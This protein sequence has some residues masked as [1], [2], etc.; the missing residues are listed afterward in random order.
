[1][2]LATANITA[3]TVAAARRI[4]VAC[5]EFEDA[6]RAGCPGRWDECL[7][8][9][10]A[11]ERPALLRQLLLL[12]WEYR[13]ERGD[14]LDLTEYLAR[15]PEQSTLV[16]ETSEEYTIEA[17]A[18]SFS[19]PELSEASRR[20][21][22]SIGYQMLHPLGRGGM[23]TVY[24]ACQ[25]GAD[26]LVAIKLLGTAADHHPAALERFRREARILARLQHPQIVQVFEVG[27][28]QGRPFYSME[29]C[30]GGSLAEYLRQARL[31]PHDAAALIEVLARAVHA[32]HQAGIIHRDLKPS[33]VLLTSACSDSARLRNPKLADFG[34]AKRVDATAQTQTGAV[35]GTP[36]YMAPEQARGDS[37]EV[38]AAADVYALGAILYECLTG[39]PP[40]LG[41]TIF[42]TVLQVI[43]HDAV[44]PARLEPRL[45]RDLNTI[46]LKCLR[47]D[48]QQRYA[49]AAA[50]AEDLRRFRSGEPIVARPVGATARTWRWTRRHPAAAV[51][52]G[53]LV[54]SSVVSAGLAVWA[55]EEQGSAAAAQQAADQHKRQNERQLLVNRV[56]DALNMMQ[57]H[58]HVGGLLELAH[59]L[60]TTVDAEVKDVEQS[61][62]MQLGFWSRELRPL[63][64]I[65]AEH[66]KHI[67]GV[68]YSPDGK[69]VLSASADHTARL[70]DVASG[71]SIGPP[72][73]HP[74]FV[75][76]VAFSPDGR[77]A[78]TGCGDGQARLWD[79]ATGQRIGP[80]LKHSERI[81]A[82]AFSP[83]G[84]LILTG[85]EDKTAKLWDTATGTTLF[86]FEHPHIV[87]SV[88]FS[89]SGKTV[90]TGCDDHKARMW[91]TATGEPYGPEFTHRGR[92]L[93]VAFTNVGKFAVTGSSDRTAQVWH[94]VSGEPLGP[95]LEHEDEVFAVAF[96]P[97]G[98]T[99]LTS[100]ED[101][102]TRL[103]ENGSGIALGC[104]RHHRR[105]RAAAFSPDGKMVLTGNW[106]GTARLWE[107][108]TLPLITRSQRVTHTA[109]SPD[110]KTVLTIS[111]RTAVLCEAATGKPRN[112][113]FGHKDG[114]VQA[115]AFSPDGK[116]AIT[117]TSHGTV[118]HWNATTSALDSRKLDDRAFIAALSP[119]G[120]TALT[121]SDDH[122]AQLWET[123]TG[124]RR[125]LPM[126]HDGRIVVAVFSPDGKNLLTATSD[127]A[128]L[129][130]CATGKPRGTPLQHHG[131]VRVA[132]F[133]MDGTKALTGSNDGRV[134]LWDA[135]TGQALHAP[136]K[137]GS[138]ITVVASSPNGR[139]F[140]TGTINGTAY[141]RDSATGESRGA[142]LQHDAPVLAA[143]FNPDG[144]IVLT[145]S[146][147]HLAQLWETGTG[148]RL[149]EPLK[150][151]DKV[152]IVKF[153]P[154]GRVALTGSWDG[155]TRF[156]EIF[157]PV[158]GNP[159]RIRLW[160]QVIT[161]MERDEYGKIRA[162]DGQK[163]RDY[164]QSLDDSRGSLD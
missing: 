116:S 161:G 106:D 126:Q 135:T 113:P 124:K 16:L 149:G 94:V 50:L 136:L 87:R 45:P 9:V 6:L 111:S 131:G 109:F 110:G 23:G 150:H 76:S 44:P 84:T 33:N 22:E 12:E 10:A 51:P 158:E 49:D 71:R 127:T 132:T 7:E 159:E 36:Q 112:V 82:A 114:V 133:S 74:D 100:C 20:E 43:S 120:E 47:K 81:L 61:I 65:F 69:Q 79:L 137:H 160:A 2:G 91:S 139:L 24:L 73:N 60:P 128:R 145:G 53:V 26:R 75:Y 117:A 67:L 153:S 41:S 103:W 90:L 88:D 119:D 142:P 157:S 31:S 48:P 57:R 3:L 130:D 56:D 118:R 30:P 101:G 164:K 80:L 37:K 156:W 95:P 148:R 92:V 147:D 15:F 46:C 93:A 5:D 77:T 108:P 52:L 152:T 122:T 11:D 96:S 154:D 8:S 104:L 86:N 63:R 144:K 134:Q 85:S 155:A 58:D 138:P 17:G 162:I 4:D 34:L 29:Y 62:R 115:I 1:M 123:A 14:R 107:A 102:T 42:E 125:G 151:K 18:S 97:D 25:Q 32:A 40:F 19:P 64:M 21:W 38:G 35:L 105:V 78:L 146:D 89:Y 70:W 143:A 68:A 66:Q 99:I 121:S 163:W 54:L 27:E 13:H 72:L 141:L 98:K 129:W 28:H 55:L 39:R 140:L 59:I 83:D